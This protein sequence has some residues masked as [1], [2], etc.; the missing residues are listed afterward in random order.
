MPTVV[1]TEQWK[2]DKCKKSYK[3]KEQA[4]SCERDC[5]RLRR[6]EEEEEEAP[7]S[8]QFHKKDTKF[9]KYCICCG[10]FVLEYEYTENGV[11]LYRFDKEYPRPILRKKPG[12]V[13]VL[14][15]LWCPKCSLHLAAILPKIMKEI[16]VSDSL[17]DNILEHLETRADWKGW[18]GWN[19]L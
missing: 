1:Y 5:I 18:K 6:R 17:K 15:G 10:T 11:Y 13:K 12:V 9:I 2:C 3:T 14:E 7:R 16:Y 4:E 19:N 8:L